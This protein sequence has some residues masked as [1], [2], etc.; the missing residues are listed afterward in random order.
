MSAKGIPFF[1][2]GLN[3]AL[4]AAV[5]ALLRAMQTS[6]PEPGPIDSV[7]AAPS[8]SFR[9]AKTNII[10]NSK[11]FN[12]LDIESTNYDF[13]VLNLRGIGC[14]EST[15]RDI[16]LADVNQLYARKRR[17]LNIT[18][19]DIQW[20][21]SEP[22]PEELRAALQKAQTLE[23]ERKKLLTR[24]L[25]PNWDEPAEAPADSLP[26]NGPTLSTLTPEQNQAVQEIVARSRQTARA[27]VKE[28]EKAGENPEALELARMREATRR[29]LEQ[30]LTPQQLEEFL[31]R[32]SSNASQLR[33]ELRGA[34]AT[35]DE[36]RRL[37]AST[38]PI[39]R[40]LQLLRDDD[41]PAAASRRKELQRKRD[42][43]VRLALTPER[44]ETYRMAREADYRVAMTEARELGASAS[45]GHAL[46]ELNQAAA[47]EK[48]RIR[49][50][51]SLTSEQKDQELKFIEYEREA[52]RARAL[53]L[54]LPAD[55]RMKPLPRG[56]HSIAAGDT[57]ANLSLYYRV[58]LSELV[59]A[60]PGI[61]PAN[62]QPGQALKIPQ[63]PPMP[64]LQPTFVPAFGRAG[65]QP[66][67]TPTPDLIP[68]RVP[69]FGRAGEPPPGTFTPPLI[70]NRV[71]P[72]GRAGAPQ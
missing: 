33:E 45:A 23:E 40:E 59:R 38:D 69:P 34:N 12:W 48:E 47:A 55:D 46:Y 50:D 41:D 2:L 17:E 70:P 25:G 28:R 14:P 68:N 51:T 21:R 52:A 6:S 29:E 39:D 9:V 31:L 53:G 36:F 11:T 35:P 30:K 71:P 49:N 66:P 56:Q 10:L 15:V 3:V 8:T 63:L 16:I 22:D 62:L 7:I 60:N 64:P 20:W 26:L 19:N 58:P 44:Y 43:A 1:S 42:E 57:L 37:F 72:F 13:Y 5:I 65:E 54:E 4:A 67:G 27:Y 61:D 32:Y 24:L 18:T